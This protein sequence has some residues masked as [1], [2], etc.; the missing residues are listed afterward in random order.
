MDSSNRSGISNSTVALN[1]KFNSFSFALS[2]IL[3]SCCS[4]LLLLTWYSPSY[5]LVVRLLRWLRNTNTSSG[6]VGGSSNSFRY[7]ISLTICYLF[8][9]DAIDCIKINLIFL[10]RTTM[11]LLRLLY[12]L[13]PLAPHSIRR[14]VH[15]LELLGGD[16]PR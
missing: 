13:P 1:N 5:L 4:F 9:I 8:T 10:I 15:P 6:V 2:I 3:D 16:R 14:V 12:L 7:Y 11:R